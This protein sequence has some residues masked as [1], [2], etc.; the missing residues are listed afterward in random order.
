MLDSVFNYL[1]DLKLS[2]E[3]Y[4]ALSLAA[5]VGFLVLALK[6][7]G[8]KLHKAQ[9]ELLRA[10]VENQQDAEDARVA[11]LRSAF[12]KAYQAYKDAK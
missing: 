11:S 1:K 7:Q 9:V 4:G 2:L 10:T 8:G 3:S 6:L 12:N 5:L